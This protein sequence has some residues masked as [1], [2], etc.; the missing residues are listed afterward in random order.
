MKGR[1]VSLKRTSKSK[2]GHMR[3]TERYLR[4][5][6]MLAIE[7]N[8]VIGLRLM[9]LMRGGRGARREAER[10]VA[11][12]IHAALEAGAS[13]MTGARGNQIVRRYRRRVTANAK[14]LGRLKTVGRKGR[15]RTGRD[16]AR[17]R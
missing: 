12:K 16:H 3:S 13:M 14:R 11:E 9:K 6:L 7:S 4:S 15:K 1:P 10:M 17:K 8:G 5:L 2:L